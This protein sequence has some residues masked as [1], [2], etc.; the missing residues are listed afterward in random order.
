MSGSLLCSW[1]QINLEAASAYC[2][3]QCYCMPPNPSSTLLKQYHSC[4][5]SCE[6]KCDTSQ[7]ILTYSIRET[8]AAKLHSC[9]I[10]F[11]KRQDVSVLVHKFFCWLHMGHVQGVTAL[12]DASRGGQPDIVKLLL[13]KGA[14]VGMVDNQVRNQ[15]STSAV[16]F[17]TM[18]SGP[19]QLV[20][21][22]HLV[23]H[24]YQTKQYYCFFAHV[25][26]CMH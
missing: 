23:L 8:P 1:R 10:L 3:P 4:R 12:I 21:Q 15:S 14:N 22:Q 20:S 16:W 18:A 5:R 7:P 24:S 9:P 6:A 13:S 11:S 26:C 17:H 25:P 2:K 19:G